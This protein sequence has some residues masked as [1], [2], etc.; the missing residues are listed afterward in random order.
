MVWVSTRCRRD[1]FDLKHSSTAAGEG[2]SVRVVESSRV[3]SL[4]TP[5]ELTFLCAHQNPLPL[6]YSYFSPCQSIA[7]EFER[8]SRKYPNVVF[9]KVDVDKCKPVA[10][11]QGISAMPTFQ[12]YRG[13]QKFFGFRG[14]SV[15]KLES[16]I[17]KYSAADAVPSDAFEDEGSMMGCTLL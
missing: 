6:D 8:L 14:A 13:G 2:R 12:F 7:P 9:L 5:K 1:L 15:G 4:P 3:E 10:R 16:S 11:A 17:Q